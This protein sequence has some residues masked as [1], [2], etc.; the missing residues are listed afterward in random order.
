MP[1]RYLAHP[2]PERGAGQARTA[3]G[4]W[5][6]FEVP[7]RASSLDSYT[8]SVGID[9]THAW[10]TAS[11][12]NLWP[13]KQAIN[14]IGDWAEAVESACGADH[15]YRN[16]RPSGERVRCD[17]GKPCWPAWQGVSLTPAA[18]ASGPQL[19]AMGIQPVR[20]LVTV[21][22]WAS[23]LTDAA[24][25]GALPGLRPSVSPSARKTQCRQ[26]FLVYTELVGPL[27]EFHPFSRCLLA[28]EGDA[29]SSRM[30]EGLQWLG[31]AVG[32]RSP[33]VT[34]LQMP[35]SNV[36]S[37][38]SRVIPSRSIRRHARAGAYSAQFWSSLSIQGASVS[39]GLA[40]ST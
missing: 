6:R 13:Y 20:L 22:N 10:V 37:R 27:L 4:V 26:V 12:A 35:R 8:W 2:C 23:P 11:Y 18:A 5:D 39:R 14:Q 24:Q 29:R 19:V 3:G 36:N 40:S 1:R 21:V 16:L 30:S 9:A 15:G 33:P 7:G 32:P 28:G 25:L 17:G 38:S 34:Q 31:A